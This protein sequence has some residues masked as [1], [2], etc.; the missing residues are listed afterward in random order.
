MKHFAWIFVLCIAL[1]APVSA[2]A[3]DPGPMTDPNG[4]V[5]IGDYGPGIDPNG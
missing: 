3:G 2:L 1:I 4:L 5:P